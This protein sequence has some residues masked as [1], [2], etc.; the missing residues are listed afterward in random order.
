MIDSECLT[1]LTFCY[2]FFLMTVL[3]LRRIYRIFY[4][5]KYS[6]HFT[7]HNNF[8][9][10]LQHLTKESHRLSSRT[11]LERIPK[12]KGGMLLFN[13]NILNFPQIIHQEKHLLQKHLYS[14][15]TKKA[16]RTLSITKKCTLRFYFQF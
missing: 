11:N 2:L 4:D 16:K 12:E 3:G 7:K 10:Y 13:I 5:C 9:P 1:Q 15:A 14:Q 6:K 8:V